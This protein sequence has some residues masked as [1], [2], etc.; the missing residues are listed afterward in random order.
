MRRVHLSVVLLAC[1]SASASAQTSVFTDTCAGAATVSEGVF[2]FDSAAFVAAGPAVNGNCGGGNVPKPADGWLLYAPTAPGWAAFTTCPTSSYV[3]GGSSSF[4]SI[5]VL[6]IWDGSTC[7]PTQRLTCSDSAPN[8]GTSEAE[9]LMPVEAGRT[10]WVQCVPLGSAG[11]VAQVAIGL[12]GDLG[13]PGPGDS[14]TTAVPKTG[15][16]TVT[17]QATTANAFTAVECA[18]YPNYHDQWIAYTASSTGLC[19]A[20]TC[21]T[22]TLAPGG[23]SNGIATYVAMHRSCPATGFGD[24][25]CDNGVGA[26]CGFHNGGEIS[27][28]CTAG[29]TYLIQVGDHQSSASV[30]GVVVAFQESSPTTTTNPATGKRYFITPGPTTFHEA[31]VAAETLGARLTSINDAAEQAWITSTF[32]AN[33][34]YWIGLS[35]EATEGAFVWD[36][37]RPTTFTAWCA[38]APTTCGAADYVHFWGS[39]QFQWVAAGTEGFCADRRRAVAEFG[40]SLKAPASAPI[41]STIDYRLFTSLPQRLYWFDASLTGSSPGVPVAPGIVIPLNEPWLNFALGFSYPGFVGFVGISD[42]LGKAQAQVVLP[43]A[44]ALVGATLTASFAELDLTLPS[45]VAAV[46]PARDTALLA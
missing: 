20:S 28:A 8:C 1:L 36:D 4:N 24:V 26:P 37:G 13:P 10:Y 39:C 14:C 23:G 15:P 35:D 17:L 32:A 22:S 16:G 5:L 9:V 21:L 18:T 34:E 40:T 29:T 7:P 33:Q 19:H 42:A 30:A 6:G 46:A 38:T 41:G 12:L 44:P 11:A 45:F 27:F 31:R 25:V 2:H 3:S 43:S